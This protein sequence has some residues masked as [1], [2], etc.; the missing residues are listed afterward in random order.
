MRSMLLTN[1]RCTK[2][3]C[4]SFPGGSDGKE[5][6]CKVTVGTMFH[7]RSEEFMPII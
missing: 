4:D 2:Y 7:S 6:A 5:S 1:F 3:Y